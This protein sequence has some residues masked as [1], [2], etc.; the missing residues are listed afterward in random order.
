MIMVPVPARF[1]LKTSKLD[2]L[3][4]RARCIAGTAV[5]TGEI[6]TE[7]DHY[8]HSFQLVGICI[9]PNMGIVIS[10]A[11]TIACKSRECCH[12]LDLTKLTSRR[13]AL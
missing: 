4:T 7:A 2:I 13:G 6:T 5:T 3:F 10:P 1:N 8:D 11:D 12:T 9:L